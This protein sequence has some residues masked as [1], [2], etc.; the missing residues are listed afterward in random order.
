MRRFARRARLRRS[1]CRARLGRGLVGLFALLEPKTLRAL[2]RS[3]NRRSARRKKKKRHGDD[4]AGGRLAER[5]ERN[6]DS[7]G[8]HIGF[9]S[10]TRGAGAGRRQDIDA[11]IYLRNFKSNASVG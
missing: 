5:P 10:S 1:L 4:F 11:L 7:L 2:A 8:N 3:E 9:Q 6:C